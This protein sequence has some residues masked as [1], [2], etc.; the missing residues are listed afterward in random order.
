MGVCFPM[1]SSRSDAEAAVRAVRYPPRGDRFWGPFFAPLRW[2]MSMSDYL[3]RADDEVLAIATIEHID[4]VRNIEEIAATP[5]LDLAFI[6]P[7]DDEHGAEGSARSPRC[8]GRY[9]QIGKRDKG[10]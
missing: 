5:G 7:G 3:D 8:P 4:A 2:D 1:I 9:C 6:G 10:Q